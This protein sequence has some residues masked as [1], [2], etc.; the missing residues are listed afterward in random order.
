MIQNLLMIILTL[1]HQL[2]ILYM[3]LCEIV[4][5]LWLSTAIFDALICRIYIF[6]YTCTQCDGTC[7]LCK[8]NVMAHW[9]VDTHYSSYTLACYIYIIYTDLI[10]VWQWVCHQACAIDHFADKY[11][12]LL[13]NKFIKRENFSI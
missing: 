1:H 10:H 11:S 3:T 13:I 6:T 4:N 9:I 5:S 2:L 8:Y 7:Q 12:F